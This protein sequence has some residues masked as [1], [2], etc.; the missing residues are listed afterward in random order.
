MKLRIISVVL[1]TILC[2]A[3][4]IYL[5]DEKPSSIKNYLINSKT[6]CYVEN[7]AMDMVG[8]QL[9]VENLVGN[10]IYQGNPP[11]YSLLESMGLLLE[12]AALA[13][14]SDLFTAVLKQTI[15]DFMS[16]EGYFYWRVSLPEKKGSTT[17]A[18][19]DDLRL[20]KAIYKMDS[21]KIKGESTVINRLSDSIFEFDV[22][23]GRFIDYYDGMKAKRLSLFYIDVEAMRALAGREQRWKAPYYQALSVLRQAPQN[24]EG[25]FPAW[26]DQVEGKYHYPEEVNMIENLYTA[27]NYQLAGK[28]A[29]RFRHF[30]AKELM[31]GKISCRYYLDGSPV[32]EDESAAVYALAYRLF[33]LAGDGQ[34]AS[35]CYAKMLGFQIRDNSKLRGGFGDRVAQNVHSF[36]QLEALLTIRMKEG[37]YYAGEGKRN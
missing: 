13:G 16:P 4:V 19:V 1:V 14:N 29:V 5:Q 36:D 2:I 26:Y 33:M 10:K 24:K 17:T 32:K 31:E 12:Y 15:N 20:I 34:Y 7:M 9:I 30:L 35:Q 11:R 18:L 23:E 27:I 6:A 28:D 25:F 21:S 22:R 8:K 3:V 37:N